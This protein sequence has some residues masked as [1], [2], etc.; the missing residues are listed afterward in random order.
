VITF[1]IIKTRGM[2]PY[3]LQ[4]AMGT[5]SNSMD[6]ILTKIQAL[7]AE[8]QDVHFFL[9][10]LDIPRYTTYGSGL[11]SRLKHLKDQKINFEPIKQ[12]EE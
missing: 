9:D 2:L 4:N 7:E 11:G 10:S 3:D 12:E 5:I 6:S 8:L 1:T